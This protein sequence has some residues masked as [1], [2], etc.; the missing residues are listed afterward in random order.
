MSNS[1]NPVTGESEPADNYSVD[2]PR[3]LERVEGDASHLIKLRPPAECTTKAG[4]VP[5]SGEPDPTIRRTIPRFMR[6]R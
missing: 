6:N 1:Y 5:K 3:E 2:R 4:Y